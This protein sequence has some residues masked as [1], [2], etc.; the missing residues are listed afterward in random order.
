MGQPHVRLARRIRDCIDRS[1]YREHKLTDEAK[2]A[3]DLFTIQA[4]KTHYS[5][6]PM[7]TQGLDEDAATLTRRLLALGVQIIFLSVEFDKKDK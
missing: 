3:L 6:E 4:Y 1:L 2:L 7:V 5:I